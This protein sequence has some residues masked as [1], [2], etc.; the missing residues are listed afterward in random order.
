MST[1][2]VPANQHANI[3]VAEPPRKK[4]QWRNLAVGSAMNI[5][6]VTT[7][8]QPMEVLKTHVCVT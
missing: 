4:I 3:D 1:A 8:G 2:I 5:F 6:Q 7:L